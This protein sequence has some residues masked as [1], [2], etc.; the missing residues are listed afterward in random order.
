MAQ[1]PIYRH[2]VRVEVLTDYREDLS[3]RTLGQIAEEITDGNWSGVMTV[4][5]ANVQ[6]KGKAA[7]DAVKEQGSDPEFFQLDD[8]G[9]ELE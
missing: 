8:E 7:V 3:E 4:E 2:V 5:R 6:L 9:N 1:K